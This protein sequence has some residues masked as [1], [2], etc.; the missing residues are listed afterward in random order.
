MEKRLVQ[1]YFSAAFDKISNCGLVYKLRFIGIE[2]QFLSTVSE[3][4]SDRRLRVRLNVKVSAS[5]NAVSGVPQ[6][7]V[8]VSLLFILHT[9][10]LFHIVGNRIVGYANDTT[11]YGFI[12]RLI[13]LPQVI[14]SKNQDLA[15]RNSC[16]LNWPRTIA[17]GY[18][19]LNLGGAELEELK[20]L[21]ILGGNLRL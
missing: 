15:A 16:C 8:L 13:S 12:I 6:D 7:S 1:L 5:A 9:S 17:F 21:R 2:K 10:E 11:S 20:R 18:G 3:F 4:L 14:E 19:D